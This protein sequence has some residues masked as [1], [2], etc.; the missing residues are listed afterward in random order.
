MDALLI[1]LDACKEAKEW[2]KDKTW[3]EV[4]ETCERGDWL[5]WLFARTNPN[6]LKELTLAKGHCANTVRYLIK[7]E[8]SLKAVDMALSQAIQK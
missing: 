6:N 8:R 3:K 1:T 5:L 4:Y 2:A 7:D